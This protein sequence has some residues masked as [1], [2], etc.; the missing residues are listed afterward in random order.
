M[1]YILSDAEI[2]FNCDG[3]SMLEY[4]GNIH[5]MPP[6]PITTSRSNDASNQISLL[7]VDVLKRFTITF[8]QE[9]IILANRQLID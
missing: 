3:I 5:V 4:V 7:G 6:S 1:P 8:V 2:L 9:K